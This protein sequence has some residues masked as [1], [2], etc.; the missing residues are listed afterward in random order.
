M[1]TP[2]WVLDA[3]DASKDFHYGIEDEITAVW[4]NPT[5]TEQQKQCKIDRLMVN[6]RHKKWNKKC[7]KTTIYGNAGRV[8]R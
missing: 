4:E 8:F 7:A 1:E 2:Y 5:F 3:I 6:A